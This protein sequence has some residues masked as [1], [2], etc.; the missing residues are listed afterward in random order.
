VVDHAVAR[1]RKKIEPDPH[2]PTF[3]RAAMATS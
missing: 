2:R 3:I 1:L